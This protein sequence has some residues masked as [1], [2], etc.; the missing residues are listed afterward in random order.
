MRRK[1]VVNDRMQK[2][3]VYYRTEPVGRNF[4]PGFTPELTPK[5]MLALGVFGGKYMTDC[6]GE[7]PASWFARATLCAER[8]DPRLNCFGVNASQSLAEERRLSQCFRMAATCREMA[9]HRNSRRDRAPA[10]AI[11]VSTG[12]EIPQQPGREPREQPRLNRASNRQ[13]PL[14][15]TRDKAVSWVIYRGASEKAPSE[16]LLGSRIGSKWWTI[17]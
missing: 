14:P 7:F 12:D 1:V 5:Q 13:T 2:G 15:Q 10:P 8:H 3:Y 17:W 6:R 9:R 16:I 11:I 4:A